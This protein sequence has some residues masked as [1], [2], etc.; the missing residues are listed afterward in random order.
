MMKKINTPK[1]LVCGI[2]ADEVP[3]SEKIT[4]CGC[5]KEDIFSFLDKER[6]EMLIIS[7]DVF[8]ENKEAFISAG[9]KIYVVVVRNMVSAVSKVKTLSD[10]FEKRNRG[11]FLR[12]FC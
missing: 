6:I 8:K 9:K 7:E 10:F 5:S 3:L 1:V 11:N 2:N 4:I 12:K